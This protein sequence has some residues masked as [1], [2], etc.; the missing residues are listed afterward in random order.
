MLYLYIVFFGNSF[1]DPLSAIFV[2]FQFLLW[3]KTIQII[4]EHLDNIKY[5]S[6]NS[7]L[8]T[9]NHNILEGKEAMIL[10]ENDLEMIQ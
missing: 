10:G 5:A 7:N 2:D 4:C 1:L 8:I 6:W 3:A 9:Q